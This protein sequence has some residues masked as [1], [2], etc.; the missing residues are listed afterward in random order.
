M[1]GGIG[2]R[3]KRLVKRVVGKL[4]PPSRLV[5]PLNFDREVLVPANDAFIKSCIEYYPVKPAVS[6]HRK[7]PISLPGASP[8]FEELLYS[9]FPEAF[10]ARLSQATIISSN[11]WVCSRENEIFVESSWYRNYPHELNFESIVL[12]G[13]AIRLRGKT[14]SLLSDHHISGNYGHVMLDCF[15]RLALVL[16]SEVGPLAGFKHVILPGPR[17]EKTI[18][19][20]EAFGFRREQLL[21]GSEFSLIQADDLCVTSFPGL[22]RNYP[23]WV[24][25]FLAKSFSTKACPLDKKRRLYVQRLG[26]RKIKNEDEVV[27]LLEGWGFEVYHPERSSSQ[28]QDFRDAEL[29]LGC[30][31]A[32]LTNIVFCEPGTPV[33][34]LIPSDHVH[35][36][37]YTLADSAGH[38]YHYI[39][40]KSEKERPVG[41]FGPS[42]YDVTVNLSD[43]ES[44]LELVLGAPRALSEYED[45]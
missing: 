7:K 40:T 41:S 44:M 23:V 18:G 26:T 30:H 36:Y 15:S 14:L 11:G 24:I 45:R 5:I 31:G 20:A 29:V 37:Y 8:I 35:P 17:S 9:E 1:F 42:P 2:N 38:P 12:N 25:Q 16:E 33:I 21:F 13:Q 32:G 19:C 4:V 6:F 27:A 28:Y 39:V 34:E 22:R 10:V 43:L 3:S